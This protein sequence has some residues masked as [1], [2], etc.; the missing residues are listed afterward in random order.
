MLRILQLTMSMLNS[1]VSL[2][3][4]V[5]YGGCLRSMKGGRLA[6]DGDSRLAEAENRYQNLA[7]SRGSASTGVW[8]AVITGWRHDINLLVRR[9][10]DELEPERMNVSI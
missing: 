1:G 7:V 2:C 3:S 10:E 5:N 4:S 9:A 6:S 8:I